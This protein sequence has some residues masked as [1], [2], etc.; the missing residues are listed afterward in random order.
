MMIIKKISKLIVLP[1][2]IIQAV[3]FISCESNVKYNVS[4]SYQ[5]IIDKEFRFNVGRVI[6]VTISQSIE[7]DGDISVDG[8]YFFYSSNAD[9]GNFDIYLRAM[10]DI[11]TVRLTSHPSKDTN[12]V[13]SPDGKSLAFVSFR[14]DPE[15]DIF[16]VN[17]DPDELLKKAA[18]G[19]DI[20]PL[21]VETINLTVEKDPET[22]V[23]TNKKDSTPCWSP[24]GKYIAYSSGKEGK[25]EIW[26]MKSDGSAKKKITSSGG[27][28]PSFSPD[29]KK[30]IFVSYSENRYG[31]IYSA[32]IP[33]GKTNRL[34]TGDFIKLYPSYMKD[35]EKIIYS[36]IEEDTNSDGKL[37]IQDRSVIRFLDLKNG[38]TYPLTMSS[39]TSFK[40]KWTPAIQTRDYNGAIIYTDLTEKNIN[41]NI[42]PEMGIIPKK[43][44]IK[45]Q[46]DLSDTYLTE[47]DDEERYSMALESVYN[48]YGKKNDKSSKAYTNRALK[49]AYIYY[50]TKRHKE[51]SERIISVIKER[52]ANNDLYAS[53]IL[54]LIENRQSGKNSLIKKM[55]ADTNNKYFAPFAME[56]LAD[57]DFDRGDKTKAESIYKEILKKYPSFER[58]K[59]ILTKIALSTDNIMSGSL[60]DSAV[61][62]LTKGSPNQK[63]SVTANIVNPFLKEKFKTIKTSAIIHNIAALKKKHHNEKKIMAILSLASGLLNDRTNKTDNARKDL[64]ESIKLSHPNDF[65]CYL[66]NIKLAEI[67]RRLG[68]SAEAEK[69]YSAGISRYSRRFKTENFRE[70]L[71]WLINY[72]EQVGEKNSAKGNFKSASEIYD[73]Y[74]DIITQ[75]HNK[76]LYPEIYSEYAPRAHVLYIDA[77]SAWKGEEGL[78]ELE[79]KY[80]KNLNV[81][82][83][84]RDRAALYGYAY[85][86]TKKA[87]FEVSQNTALSIVKGDRVF[88][89]LFEADKQIEWALFYD[90]TFIEP[91]LLK[92]WIYQYVDLQR[93]EFGDDIES[94]IE[95]FFPKRLWEKNIPILERALNANNEELQPENEGN[96]HLNMGNSYFLLLNYPRALNHY[97]LA[98]KYKKN[99]GTDIEKA[100]FHFHFGYT[101]WQNGEIKEAR[102]EITKAYGVY[103]TLSAGSSRKYKNQMLTLY[104]YFALFSRYEGKYREA[105]RWYRRIIR[106]AENSGIEIDNARYLQEIAHCYK[107]TGDFDSAKSYIQQADRLL[108]DYPDD[109]RKYYLRIKLFGI[110]PFPVFN[111]GPD[112]AVIGENKIFYPLDT[113]N[114]KLLSIS[115]LEAISVKNSNYSGAIKYLKKKI[116]ILEESGTAVAVET[117]IRSLNNL[118]YYYFMS[119]DTAGAEKYFMEAGELA[120][121]KENL[122]GIF[123][124]MM[125]T[126]NLYAL[127]IE[128]DGN[129]KTDWLTKTGKFLSKIE[130]YRD[131]YYDMKFSQEKETLEETADAEKRDLTAEELEE[132]KK[133]IEE[134]TASIYYELDTS[135]AIMKF[136]RAEL[137]YSSAVKENSGNRAYNLYARNRE[138]YTLYAEALKMFEGAIPVA[139]SQGK[140]EL[141]IKL[142]INAAS[143]YE[144]TGEHEKAYVALIDARNLSEQY[145]LGWTGILANYALGNFLAEYGK[146]VESGDYRSLA[147][148]YMSASVSRIEEHPLLYT[149]RAGRIKIIYNG[150][151]EFLIN[152]GR[153]D[154]SFSV[155]ERLSR[156]D[157]ITSV[158]SINP[159]FSDEYDMELYS[160]YISEIS[161]LSEIR[162]KRSSLLMS[163]S[164][165]DSPEITDLNTR[166]KKQN[167]L[168]N[169]LLNNIRNR[170]IAPYIEPGNANYK[171]EYDILSFART[172]DGLYSWTLSN[173][174][175][176]SEYLKSDSADAITAFI[177][178]NSL[179]KPVFILANDTSLELIMKYRE[180]ITGDFAFINCIDRA[181]SFSSGNYPAGKVLSA[182]GGVGR[183]LPE[184]SVE[185]FSDKTTL[186]GYAV[187]IEKA[188]GGGMFTPE[189]LFSKSGISP[190]YI[191]LS[192]TVAESSRLSLMLEAA[193][194]SGT[195]SLI[196]S[197]G[198]ELSGILSA[199]YSGKG[200]SSSGKKYIKAGYINALNDKK[201]ADFKKTADAEYSSFTENLGDGRLA[202]AEVSLA[203]WDAMSPD[204]KYK[205][206]KSRWLL[207]LLKGDY[208]AAIR[209]LETYTPSSPEEDIALKLRRIYTLLHKGDFAQAI[210]ERQKITGAAKYQDLE[211]I[212]A[213]FDAV[214]GRDSSCEKILKIKKPYSTLLPAERYLVLASQYI[215]LFNPDT[216]REIIKIEKMKYLSINEQMMKF[217][218]T[219]ENPDVKLSPRIDRILDLALSSSETAADESL[220]LIKSGEAFDSISVYPPLTV[221]NNGLEDEPARY[222]R[223][224]DLESISKVAATPA[225]IALLERCYE[226]AD[227][228]R[229]QRQKLSILGLIKKVSS[230]SSIFHKIRSSM[231][232]IAVEYMI[233]GSYSDAYNE[234]SAAD[235]RFTP[236]DQNYA[237]LQLLLADLLIK[238]GDYN[239][240]ALK[241]GKVKSLG[242]LKPE[243]KYLLNLQLSMIELNRLS[244]LKKATTADAALF[245]KLFSSSLG[246]LKLNPAVLNIHGYREMTENVFDE[247]I[248][249]KM[250]TGQHSDAHYYNEMKKLILSS[251]VTGVN[252]VK[253]AGTIDITAIQQALPEKCGYLNI[254]KVK[255]DLFVWLVD[256]KMKKALWIE[257]G[258]KTM[259]G[260]LKKYRLAVLKDSDVKKASGDLYTFFEPFATYFKSRKLLLISPDSYTEQ[261]PFEIIGKG[262][263]LSEELRIVYLASPLLL[264]HSKGGTLDRVSFVGGEGSGFQSHVEM[265]AARESG[266]S[267]GDSKSSRMAHV[268]GDIQYTSSEK[269]FLVSGRT[270]TSATGSPDFLYATLDEYSGAGPVDF[271]LS[272]RISGIK[273][274]MINTSPVSELNRG[275]FAGGFYG[276]LAEG[277]SLAV[278]YTT[279]LEKTKN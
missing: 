186:S 262:K 166:E 203:R 31:D 189:S 10:G 103:S 38:L 231:Y 127:M 141:K 21:D 173:G 75:M 161:K 187:L 90:D 54:N 254:S 47:Y 147:D 41:L 42:I 214:N 67:E 5:G 152:S 244:S 257:G 94:S 165:S 120:A 193:L 256:K 124:S 247:Y 48:L 153:K 88:K 157:R 181:D 135:I 263:M 60:S 241:C 130:N 113:W 208:A 45:L 106:F 202:D 97:R 18:G 164:A 188:E 233:A 84:D 167:E 170:K 210:V 30:I 98:E 200:F 51:K 184:I 2:I 126:A 237:G 36:S 163:G 83:M 275:V 213:V 194:Y 81:L 63:I 149:S 121:E 140:L 89:N 107:E 252:L 191:I 158:N 192:G 249:Y 73:K 87:M 266:I 179:K 270:L 178:E 91:Y 229:S 34:T 11:T 155:N 240:A 39:D 139:E 209:A 131:S 246:Y 185:M 156:I 82:R 85:I 76:R 12:P 69:Y 74:I 248:N 230:E 212:D 116:S 242:S 111:M 86:F 250:K 138:L 272:A 245:E 49:E 221:L 66:S 57:I 35:T 65:T 258:Y 43:A 261:I 259:S 251:A 176:T 20:K 175:I 19:E 110:G 55:S 64:S 225:S 44:N 236:E 123:S 99:F 137:L 182:A 132:L 218:I 264:T 169:R 197:Q 205:Y 144:K 108:K 150:Y 25:N 37:D 271:A 154:K 8:N 159:V 52:I 50:K 129:G 243:E 15:G 23:I 234:A 24:D 273:S 56:D 232:R 53:F 1:L 14:D 199:L 122:D 117:R 268:T 211:F 177:S 276:S 278:S 146:E 78:V 238:K 3:L 253:M 160:D 183:P 172:S 17:I 207:E 239:E 190:Y 269:G 133:R 168:L 206:A 260:L 4:F 92:S 13:I 40:A 95:G 105:I 219:G 101:L 136:Y 7:T 58:E 277:K 80:F 220:K 62:I 100:L 77:H 228:Q 216:S 143:C 9:G 235:E 118:G 104:R 274:A 204:E 196:Y 195:G 134:E 70:K 79:K 180:S 222:I 171:T 148:R 174:K 27:V 255:N 33:T 22:D 201:P 115:M 145:R 6:P 72:Y 125:N 279:A 109:T 128:N 96:I 217:I 46:Y 267:T 71:L 16:I 93:K 114:K 224:L 119:G 59:D 112:T 265:V 28:Y 32:D 223:R 68:R 26:I 227:E 29:G 198:G 102:E 215:Y 61:K 142:M 162:D 151:T 226:A